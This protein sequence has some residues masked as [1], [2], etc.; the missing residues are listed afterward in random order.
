VTNRRQILLGDG[1]A[2]ERDESIPD[3]AHNPVR[4]AEDRQLRAAIDQVPKQQLECVARRR[5]D[6]DFRDHRSQRRV[7]KLQARPNRQD[8]VQRGASVA[9]YSDQG[10]MPELEQFDGTLLDRRP[11]ETL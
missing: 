11:V 9:A 3:L 4:A 8:E 7:R 1:Q 2:A 10:V 6:G 5:D